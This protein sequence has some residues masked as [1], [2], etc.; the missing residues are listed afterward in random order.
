MRCAWHPD[1]QHVLTGSADGRVAV[2][3]VRDGSKLAMLEAAKKTDEADSEIYGLAVLS[4]SLL[5]V[6]CSDTV[7]QWDLRRGQQTAHTSLAPY[8]SGIAFGGQ[9]RNP[10]ARAYVF[11][12]ASR[13]RVLAAAVSDGTVRL[14]DA[15]TCKEHACLNAHAARGAA[16]FA[17]ALSPTSTLLATTGDDGSVLLWDLRS[18]KAPLAEVTQHSQAV[19]GVCFARPGAF[20]GSPDSGELLITGGADRVLRILETRKAGG[21]SAASNVAALRLSGPVLCMAFDAASERVATGCGSGHKATDNALSILSVARSPTLG[22]E[23]P[24]A[25]VAGSVSPIVLSK[26]VE[27]PTASEQPEAPEGA[28]TAEDQAVALV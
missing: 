8:A 5:A 4:P 11:G 17:C 9:D 18:V 22:A 26:G 1:G 21:G 24:S 7:Q 20:G 28:E 23:K 2:C 6:A 13:G 16:A 10:D 14:L 25:A 15:Q 12:M 3:A 27:Q 19:H